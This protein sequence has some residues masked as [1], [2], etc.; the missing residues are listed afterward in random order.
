VSGKN[1]TY[2]IWLFF[3]TDGPKNHLGDHQT[4][5]NVFKISPVAYVTICSN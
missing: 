3:F 4:S 2:K 5:G 1:Q